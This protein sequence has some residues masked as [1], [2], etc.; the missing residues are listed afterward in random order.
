MTSITWKPIDSRS[1]SRV[2]S[3]RH[4][5]AIRSVVV[6]VIFEDLAVL[7]E[8]EVHAGE[9]SPSGRGSRTFGRGAGSPPRITMAR[10][11][12]SF[13]DSERGSSMDKRDANP[14]DAAVDQR[15]R[16]RSAP[17]ESTFA[18]PARR[19]Q[20][21][22]ATSSGTVS[23]RGE[24]APGA[25]RCGRVGLRAKQASSCGANRQNPRHDAATAHGA[26]GTATT[27]PRPLPRRRSGSR[28]ADDD[29]GRRTAQERRIARTRATRGM[30]D[31][32]ARVAADGAGIR[33]PVNGATRS[34]RA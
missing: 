10:S 19:S 30:R 28:H 1:A 23:D 25:S 3:R 24:V 34:E 18:S 6:A 22:A 8:E 32:R 33:T 17:D 29:R 14:A 9:E 16:S 20:S 15:G 4:C 31:P 2:R 7:L 11:S 13:G 21:P 26:S 27:R 12:D 5:A